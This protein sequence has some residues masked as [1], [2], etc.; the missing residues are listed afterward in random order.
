MRLRA[1]IAL[2]GACFFWGIGFPV[3]KVLTLG[4]QQADPEV[5]TWFLSATYI[6]A[7]FLAAALVIAVAR[8]MLPNRSEVVQGVA[9]G[10]VTGIGSALAARRTPVHGSVDECV[11]HAGVRRVLA[12]G[13][14]GSSRSGP[15]PS[16]SSSVRCS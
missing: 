2:V 3:M 9:L 1:T 6:A 4:A 7:R 13:V 16:E 5:S 11:S 14:H 15:R 12:R 10:A 8:P